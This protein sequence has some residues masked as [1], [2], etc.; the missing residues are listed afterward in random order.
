MRG[1]WRERM[2]DVRIGRDRV[3]NSIALWPRDLPAKRYTLV[4]SR[5][6]AKIVGRKTCCIADGV[7]LM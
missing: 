2:R 4:Q 1:R 7:M 3:W 6:M 5:T